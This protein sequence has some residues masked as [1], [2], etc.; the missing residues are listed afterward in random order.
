MQA[1]LRN[2]LKL[3]W[4]AIAPVILSVFASLIVGALLMKTVHEDPVVAYKAMWNGAF[5]SLADFGSV[6]V[7]QT[8]LLVAGLGYTV[9]FRCGLI[10]LGVEGQLIIGAIGA[11]VAGYSLN[12]P[13]FLHI[14]VVI[15]AGALAG[16]FWGWI[17]GVL[18][19]KYGISEFLSGLMLNY[20]ATYLCNWLVVNPLRDKTQLAAQTPL[21]KTSARFPIILSDTRLHLGWVVAILLT[22]LVWL[23]LYKTRKGYEFRMNGLNPSFAEYGGINRQ[24]T[25]MWAMALS[26]ALAGIAGAIEV[27]GLHWKY[28]DMLSPGYGFDG[29]SSALLGGSTP[30]G[31]FIAS[32]L[33][34][35]LRTG[36]MGMDRVTNVPFELRNVIQSTIIFFIASNIFAGVIAQALRARRKE[37]SAAARTLHAG[38]KEAK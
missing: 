30:L 34:A 16:G 21:I 23:F 38:Q 36:A 20:I 35:A 17:A 2:W 24:R 3:D 14:P 18:R 9:A 10:N 27:Q 4:M 37:A 7:R 19:G 11:A 29:V 26:G 28:I 31:T 1:R 15:L 22:V 6:L 25:L 32:F 8:P 5:G 12:L 13:F 33:F